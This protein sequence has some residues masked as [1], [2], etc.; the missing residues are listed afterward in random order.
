M[1]TVLVSEFM[2]G[3]ALAFLENRLS[4]D[5]APDLFGDLRN[6]DAAHFGS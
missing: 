2:D 5:Y 4:V 6:L 1:A 3:S